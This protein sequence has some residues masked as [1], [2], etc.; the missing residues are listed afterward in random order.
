MQVLRHWNRIP[1]AAAVIAFATLV[2]ARAAVPG[3]TLVDLGT[4]GG[5][6]SYGA[7]VSDTGI[8]VGC[9]DVQPN[10]VH[11][12]IYEGGVMR[13]LGTASDA[14]GN[15]CALAVNDSG[16][17]AGRS[18]SGELVVWSGSGVTHL[19]VTGDVGDINDAGVVVGSYRS[20]T[21]TR[22][23]IYRDGT[24][25][26]LGT[27]GE[28]VSA[29]NAATAINAREEVVGVSNGHAFLYA[30]GTMRDLGTLGGGISIA[31]GINDRGQVVGMAFNALG[32]PGPFLF[33]GTMRA[34][35]GASESAAIAINDRMQVVGSGEGVYGYVVAGGNVTRLDAIPAVRAKG[36]HH[37]EPT[38]INA[39]GWIVGTAM[40]AEGDSRAFLLVPR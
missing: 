37:L 25:T 13:D 16:I 35:P 30:D 11:A 34:L 8:V 7:A 31:K 26:D 27:L 12:F 28:G 33:D 6:G 9:S 40:T 36:W 39:R 15:S 21:G 3:W 2:P 22:A 1:A 4:L 38:G 20:G 24:L 17:A 10:G 18:G 23:F 29:Q 32:Q 5:P 19:G 14:G